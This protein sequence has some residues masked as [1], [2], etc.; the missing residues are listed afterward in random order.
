MK[1]RENIFIFSLFI[2]YS[3]IHSKE[4]E[5]GKL[6]KLTN[7]K[8][9]KIVRVNIK[10]TCL[11]STW[12]LFFHGII[13]YNN[14]MFRR[15]DSIIR[16]L[17]QISSPHLLFDYEEVPSAHSTFSVQHE[18]TPYFHIIIIYYTLLSIHVKTICFVN[19]KRK[20]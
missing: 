12:T 3:K 2:Q 1:E 13:I 4:K 7:V 10:L 17:T 15:K 6:C 9:S 5:P 16:T 11:T 14:F 8:N 18:S 19:F 20:I